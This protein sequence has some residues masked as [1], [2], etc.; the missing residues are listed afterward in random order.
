M[1]MFAVVADH[2]NCRMGK[3]YLGMGKERFGHTKA[4]KEMDIPHA[5]VHDSVFKNL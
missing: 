2:Q 4:F 5:L 1:D 3:L